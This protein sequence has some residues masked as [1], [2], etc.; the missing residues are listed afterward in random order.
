LTTKLTVDMSAAPEIALLAQAV[1][2]LPAQPAGAQPGPAQPGPAQANPAKANPARANP[3]KAKARL[4][5]GTL[6]GRLRMIAA[7]PERWWGLVRFDPDRPAR[8]TVDQDQ[9]Y[10]AWL[11]ILPP[12]DAGQSCDCDVATMIAG[13]ATEGTGVA[14]GSAALRPGPIRVHGQQHWLRGHGAGYTV[15][16]HARA[17]RA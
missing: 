4:T 5:L 9:S 17:R 7:A 13:E 10:A 11:M 16:L 3:A 12:G 1:T 15:S 6:A 14:V 2:L 8:I